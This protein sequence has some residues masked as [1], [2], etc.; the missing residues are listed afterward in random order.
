M[1]F[2]PSSC[3]PLL[4]RPGKRRFG[5]FPCASVLGFPGRQGFPA[6]PAGQSKCSTRGRLLHFLP[7]GR[8][9]SRR[10][11]RPK[12]FP[13]RAPFPFPRLPGSPP[14][15]GRGRGC[16]PSPPTGEGGAGG[17]VPEV[18]SFPSVRP[19]EMRPDAPCGLWASS[20]VRCP[21]LLRPPSHWPVLQSRGGACPVRPRTTASA[22]AGAR[23]IRS[24]CRRP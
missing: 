2:G 11:L 8:N 13:Q 3:F 20:C 9:A 14:R 15:L 7:F 19:R 21:T 18:P 12:R 23:G 4:R 1:R 22:P 6:L 24:G 17:C 16:A 5:P 10:G